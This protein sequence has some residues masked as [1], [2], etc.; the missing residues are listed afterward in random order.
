[1]ER[2]RL[3]NENLDIR[4]IIHY[5][6]MIENDIAYSTKDE[7]VELYCDLGMLKQNIDYILNDIDLQ[8]LKLE[9][10]SKENGNQR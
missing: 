5:L 3:G 10:E 8:I 6:R 7:L 4:M 9:K 2:K 1:M